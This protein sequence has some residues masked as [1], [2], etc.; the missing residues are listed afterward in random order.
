MKKL[1][2]IALTLV[3]TFSLAAC[4]CEAQKTTPATT[5]PTK[6]PTTAPTTTPTTAPTTAPTTVPTTIPPMDPTLETNIPD[7]SVDTSMP[8]VTEFMPTDGTETETTEDNA[9]MT[10]RAR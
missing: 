8:D 10:N 3:L 6:A 2:T 9:G 1:F 4:G 7:P 5:A